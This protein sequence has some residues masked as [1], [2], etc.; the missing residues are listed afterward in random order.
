MDR[1]ALDWLFSTAPQAIAALV[2]LIVASASFIFGKIDDRIDAD[3]T[4]A[5]IGQEVKKQ[6]YSG[7]KKLLIWTLCVIGIDLLCLY[8]NPIGNDRIITYSGELNGYSIYFIALFVILSINVYVLY[9]AFEYVNKMMNPK[10]FEETTETLLKEYE[11]KGKDNANVVKIG[12]FLEHFIAFERLLRRSDI[13]ARRHYPMQKPLSINQMIWELKRMKKLTD[14]DFV[15]LQ[16]INR[17][18]NIVMHEGDISEVE[19]DID[20]KL[21]RITQNL[22]KVLYEEDAMDNNM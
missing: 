2:G 10:F 1:N 5:E 16:K 13:F 3:P 4:L 11:P 22:Q 18:R 15:S 19:K 21:V 7:L 17:L 20:E 8:L 14:E 12:V 9:S 6:I